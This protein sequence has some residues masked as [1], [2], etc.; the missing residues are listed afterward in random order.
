MDGGNGLRFSPK[1]PKK[2][3]QV[4][5]PDL[6][7][8]ETQKYFYALDLKAESFTPNTDDTVNLLKL[9]IKDAENDNVLKLVASTFD[10]DSHQVMEGHPVFRKKT[11]HLLPGAEP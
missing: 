1:Y 6:A 2:I 7:L 8:S 5:T 11:D 10:Y 9:R 4:S 3:L